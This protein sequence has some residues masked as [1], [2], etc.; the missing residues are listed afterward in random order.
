MLN[1]TRQVFLYTDGNGELETPSSEARQNSATA[2]ST[3]KELSV[4]PAIVWFEA[5][6]PTPFQ[7]ETKIFLEE[8]CRAVPG[9]RF[10]TA[11]EFAEALNVPQHKRVSQTT[12]SRVNLVVADDVSIPAWSF[13]K[14]K[15]E[16]LPSLKSES[17]ISSGGNVRLDR[18]YVKRGEEGEEEEIGPE[19]RTR[20]FLYGRDVVPIMQAEMKFLKYE[21]G[22]RG[23]KVLGTIPPSDVPVHHF[24][25]KTECLVADPNS[26]AAR[27]AMADLIEALR[28]K[29]L[30][31]IARYVWRAGV[32]PKLVVLYPSPKGDSLYLN[33]LPFAEDI[34][35]LV[36]PSLPDILVEASDVMGDFID[37]MTLSP[38]AYNPERTPNPT[39]QKFYRLVMKRSLGEAGAIQEEDLQQ[40]IAID[41]ATKAKVDKLGLPNKLR[42]HF[43]LEKVAA[44]EGGRPKWRK[45]VEEKERLLTRGE[46]KVE[47]S[48]IPVEEEE[49]K[50][51]EKIE[52]A[53]KMSIGTMDPVRDFQRMVDVKEV[54][55][56]PK[57]IDMMSR[58][59]TRLV[60]KGGAPFFPRAMNCI[61]ALRGACV[62]ER[63]PKRYNDFLRDFR[64]VC[65]EVRPEYKIW[66][67]VRQGNLGLIPMSEVSTS[68]VTDE[69][70]A[71][72]MTRAGLGPR[73]EEGRQTP[74]GAADEGD[75]MALLE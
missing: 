67:S 4:V 46:V 52:A 66:D 12:K 38:D 11:E 21:G 58:V 7:Q 18:T 44:R 30:A 59:V 37:T 39:L 73:E 51:S 16:V 2:A 74:A 53:E 20:A 25:E 31:L 33:Q 32:A 49:K 47:L 50:L 54:D 24:T 57:A 6:N 45:A 42:S 23:L 72:Y 5:D 69:Q 68:D 3:F 65:E 70:A 28:R 34:R 27:V 62:A 56:T 61:A 41:S 63:E 36:L 64:R 1:K 48:Q 10:V 29:G 17:R 55:L 43:P 22:E 71:E 35:N 19:S 26:E 9:G 14:T 75:L 8:F 13:L 40:S 15:E 60:L